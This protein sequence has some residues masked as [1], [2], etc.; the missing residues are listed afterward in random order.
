MEQ[1][2]GPHF[3]FGQKG[4]VATEKEGRGTWRWTTF[5]KR[6][7]SSLN[8]PGSSRTARP[9]NSLLELEKV[10]P[11]EELASW[12]NKRIKKKSPQGGGKEMFSKRRCS[13]SG[14]DENLC[15]LYG[16]GARKEEKCENWG[17]R[18]GQEEKREIPKRDLTL[19]NGIKGFAQAA[20]DLGKRVKRGRWPTQSASRSKVQVASRRGCL[21][22]RKKNCVWGI[23]RE[24]GGEVQEKS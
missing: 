18:S 14:L 17:D 20:E 15:Y 16:G 11:V 9:E 23:R 1:R 22:G 8:R 3:L 2:G 7:S 10:G 13:S 4:T 19:D 21:E 6:D 24:N 5:K 12:H